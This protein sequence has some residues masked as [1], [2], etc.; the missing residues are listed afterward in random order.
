MSMCRI[1]F[2]C[3]SQ[4]I[5]RPFTFTYQRKIPSTKLAKTNRENEREG[6]RRLSWV[7]ILFEA[8]ESATDRY[9]LSFNFPTDL[10][11]TE[12]VDFKEE[13]VKSNIANLESP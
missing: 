3:S 8:P 9:L 10:M 13:A 11:E 6:E 4:I 1:N 7:S 5:A 2:G 12:D